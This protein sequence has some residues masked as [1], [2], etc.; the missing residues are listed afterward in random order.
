MGRGIVY[1][2]AIYSA[3]ILIVLVGRA[4]AITLAPVSNALGD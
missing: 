3:L 4:I 1:M 2:F